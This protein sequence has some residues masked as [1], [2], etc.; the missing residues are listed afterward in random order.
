MSLA[1]TVTTGIAVVVLVA[2]LYY[3]YQYLYSSAGATVVHVTNGVQTAT[4]SDGSAIVTS[5]TNLPPLY[6]GG[7]Y[8]VSFWIYVN[9]FQYR[10]DM[11]KHILSLGGKTSSGFDTLRVYLGAYTNTLS[12]RVTSTNNGSTSSPAGGNGGSTDLLSLSNYDSEFS[13]IPQGLDQSY[14]PSCDLTSVDLQRWINITVVLNGRTC[15]VYSDGKLARSCVL[16]SFYKVDPAG[17]QLTLLDKGGF[18]G[19]ISNTSAYGY[20]LNPQEVY[21]IYMTGPER[22][23]SLYSWFKSLLDPKSAASTVYP[24][25]N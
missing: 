14:F 3:L 22:Q 19:Y 7:E 25:M 18:G 21:Q 24:K 15:D 1:S 23:Y 5:S 12:V 10:R 6:E 20:A 9:D 16:P 17:Y 13:S 11:Y 2:A 8:A 4:V